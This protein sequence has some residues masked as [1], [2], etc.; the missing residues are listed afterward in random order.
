MIQR[1]C[2]CGVI[3]GHKAPFLD[4]KETTGI[5]EECYTPYLERIR[6]EL[7]EYRAK[8]LSNTERPK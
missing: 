8:Q 4:T 7:A 2:I 3:Y 5:C 1:C 6:K